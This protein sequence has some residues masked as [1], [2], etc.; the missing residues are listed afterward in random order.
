MDNNSEL[1][2]FFYFGQKGAFACLICG[3]LEIKKC[4]ALPFVKTVIKILNY[5]TNE[6]IKKDLDG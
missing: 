1:T 4:Y 5:L 2:L 3:V 6:P